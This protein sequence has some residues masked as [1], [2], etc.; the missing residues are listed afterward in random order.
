MSGHSKWKQI[1]H[2]KAATD[3]KK[4]K[5][6]TKLVKT[7]SIAVKEKG[8]D[9]S[10]NPTLRTAIEKAKAANMPKENIDRAIKKASTENLEELLIEVYGPHGIA[11][12][13]TAITDSKN[14]TIHELKHLLGTIGGKMAEQ[15]SVRWMFEQKDR[16]YIAKFPIALTSEQEEEIVKFFEVLDENDDVQEIYSNLYMDFGLR[17]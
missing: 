16:E 8:E 13:I 12:I 9:P 11:I 2:K 1:K 6:F 3:A 5:T 4:S 14:R 7:I 15:G 17:K 10:I